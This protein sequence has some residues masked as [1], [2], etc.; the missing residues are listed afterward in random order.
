MEL[1]CNNMLSYVTFCCFF[2]RLYWRILGG[3]TKQQMVCSSEMLT[4]FYLLV[5]KYKNT[6]YNENN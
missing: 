1:L 5:T 2:K 3:V 4:L 6:A